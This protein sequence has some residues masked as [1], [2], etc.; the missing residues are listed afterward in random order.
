MPA[1]HTE[2]LKSTIPF[3][4]KIR[5]ERLVE[6]WEIQTTEDVPSVHGF[7]GQLKCGP[8]LYL[9][10]CGFGGRGVIL[11]GFLPPCLFKLSEDI[12]TLS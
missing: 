9:A 8:E 3:G 7:Q 10:F 12:T 2:L 5:D 4:N 11:P 1:F 6:A